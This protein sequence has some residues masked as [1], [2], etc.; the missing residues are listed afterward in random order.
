MKLTGRAWLSN[1]DQSVSRCAVKGSQGSREIAG[2]LGLSWQA[3]APS[4]RTAKEK[5]LGVC[6]LNQTHPL[7]GRVALEKSCRKEAYPIH[8]G[9]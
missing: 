1:R 3:Y 8:Q 5:A 7:H 2:G 4:A 6:R 9:S